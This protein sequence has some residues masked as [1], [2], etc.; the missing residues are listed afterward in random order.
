MNPMMNVTGEFVFFW[1]VIAPALVLIL[2]AVPAFSRELGGLLRA[3]W[4]RLRGA[5]RH[6]PLRH[7]GVPS[8]GAPGSSHA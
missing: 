6:R 8:P 1:Y 4:E 7:R 3:G 2:M 5:L